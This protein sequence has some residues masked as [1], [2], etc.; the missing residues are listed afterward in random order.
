MALNNMC[1][2]RVLVKAEALQKTGTFKIRGALNRV[3]CLTPE[4]KKAGVRASL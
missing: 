2:G 3:L 1:G 4:E